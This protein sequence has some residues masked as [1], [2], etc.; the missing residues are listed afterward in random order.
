MRVYSRFVQWQDTWVWSTQSRF[1]SLTGSVKKPK[2]KVEEQEKK[3]SIRT[4]KSD[5]FNQTFIRITDIPIPDDTVID[6]F[7]CEDCMVD[8]DQ[9]GVVLGV[10]FTIWHEAT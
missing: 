10:T 8:V 5:A 4:V 3:V 7:F 9:N 6:S 2:V 1:E